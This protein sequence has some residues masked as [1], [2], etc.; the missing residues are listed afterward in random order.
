MSDLCYF[1]KF[2]NEKDTYVRKS[3]IIYEDELF[4]AKLD[5]FPIA[6]RH[7]E[8]MPKRHVASLFELTSKEWQMLKPALENT[9]KIITEVDLEKIY[10]DIISNPFNEKSRELCKGMLQHIGF[11][12]KPDA[13]NFGNNDGEAAGRTIHHLH[14]HI[15]PRYLGDVPDPR[16]G[17]RN[18]IPELGN[19]CK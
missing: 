6:P 8:V 17:I 16:G 12:K 10:L 4:Y 19:Y 2:I 7:A 15:I 11:N 5:E 3:T 14:I 18:I 9:V 1:C 13:Y